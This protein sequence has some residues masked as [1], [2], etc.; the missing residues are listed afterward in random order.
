MHLRL[1]LTPDNVQLPHLEAQPQD[2]DCSRNEI[3]RRKRGPHSGDPEKPWQDQHERDE[4]DDLTRHAEHERRPRLAHGLK[5][6]RADDLHAQKRN[7]DEHDSHRAASHL[8]EL[9]VLGE[10]AEDGPREQH[11]E[12]E[13]KHGNRDCHDIRDS[14]RI[15]H[16][17]QVSCAVVVACNWLEALRHSDERHEGKEQELV[18]DAEGADRDFV[19]EGPQGV[20]HDDDEE[21]LAKLSDEG[22]KAEGGHLG[23][24]VPLKADVAQPDGYRARA[25]QIEPHC[26]EK[27]GELRD[28]GR[29]RGPTHAEPQPEDEDGI[30]DD[31]EPGSDEHDDHRRLGAAFRAD[32]VRG[33]DGGGKER[34]PGQDDGEVLPGVA[35][36]VVGG[37]ENL[38]QWL[39]EHQPQAGEDACEN[40]DHQQGVSHRPCRALLLSLPEHPGDD[41]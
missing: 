26:K 22:G 16:P 36:D 21:A 12:R 24:H 4:E 39:H 20:V 18:D 30:E 41:R 6:H 9:G 19:A 40:E 23:D 37:A 7:R 28:D 5:E 34:R 10:D 13:V 32:D 35:A 25:R 38:Q 29:H 8:D 11:D 27:G 33:G 31:V 1:F 15:A 2:R 17:R 14:H 3:C